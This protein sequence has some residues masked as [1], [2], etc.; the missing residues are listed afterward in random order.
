M[1][2]LNKFIAD[3]G[4]ASRRR[5]DQLILE[6]V[7][8][9]NGAIVTELG[10]KIKPTTDVVKVGGVLLS[11][12][13]KLTYIMLNKPKGCVTTA[14][15]EHGR[16][17]VYDYLKNV[18]ARVFPVGRLDYDTEGLLLLT[19]DGALTH[20]LTHPSREVGKTYTVKIEGALHEAEL[21][22]MRKG[23]KLAD[24]DK[25]TA[26]AKIKIVSEGA[27]S[28]YKLTIFEGR[29]RQVKR[30]FEAFEKNV[31]F[32][33]RVS[34]GD[35]KLGGLARGTHRDLGEHEVAYLKEL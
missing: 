5:A 30:M 4:H 25:K 27:I 32:L 26:P 23:V 18:T 12:P 31:I 2:R 8:S 10:T 35:L 11:K 14:S 6:G 19:N 20:A 7:V 16:K 3:S 21:A 1:V 34:I 33:K 13:E 24:D 17:T 29:N 28:T 9:V 15:D 22:T